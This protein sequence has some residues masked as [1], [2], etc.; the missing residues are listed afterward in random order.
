MM[1]LVGF[2][3]DDRTLG[4]F[5]DRPATLDRRALARLRLSLPLPKPDS[6]TGRRRP[7][8]NQVAEHIDDPQASP[9]NLFRCRAQPP[10]QGVADPAVVP[11]FA[12]EGVAVVPE[13]E[14][15]PTGGV[16]DAV[17]D[18]LVDGD[19]DVGGACRVEPAATGMVGDEPAD[20]RQ[21][22]HTVDELRHWASWLGER[23]L[24]AGGGVAVVEHGTRL[25]EAAFEDRGVAPG[26][27][28]GHESC[29]LRDRFL[30]LFRLFRSA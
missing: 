9:G 29:P 8:L 25:P 22:V 16:P 12:H 28:S 23:L 18:D 21:R 30:R 17:G 11:G 4:R 6:G 3:R 15:A 13:A 10:N 1:P 27:C 14:G 24:Q 26:N 19:H 2:Q 20:R 7:H 5:P